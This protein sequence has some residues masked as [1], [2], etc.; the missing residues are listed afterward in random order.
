MIIDTFK[1]RALPKKP[2]FLYKDKHFDSL[3]RPSVSSLS[4]VHWTPLDVVEEASDFLAVP[5]GRVL[6]V[7][8]GAGKFCIAAGNRHRKAKF[9][10]IEHRHHLVEEAE[11][12]RLLTGLDNVSFQHGNLTDLQSSDFDH[13]YFYN[14]FCEQM[15]P[16]GRIDNTVTT[17]VDLYNRYKNHF[18]VMLENKPAG[19][20]L[21]TY[22]TP[23]GEV[24]GSYAL[25][26]NIYR[27]CLKF[28][29]KA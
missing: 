15:Q 28:W 25:V 23:N 26:R 2:D 16:W 18:H 17:S 20:R 6:D 27:K 21:V 14:S 29:I 12:V 22:H 1:N 9:Y 5:G 7:G 3:Y 13:F 19:T 11:R 24:P 8:S 4:A 10:G